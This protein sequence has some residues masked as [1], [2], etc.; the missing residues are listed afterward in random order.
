MI[1]FAA[2]GAGGFDQLF[3]PEHLAS[4][5]DHHH[6]EQVGIGHQGSHHPP[7]ETVAMASVEAE[8]LHVLIGSGDPAGHV[9]GAFHGENHPH[10][11]ANPFLTV[12]TEPAF[13]YP[14]IGHGC[15]RFLKSVS[16]ALAILWRCTQS[17]GSIRTMAFPIS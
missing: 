9:F 14:P 5:T 1:G 4:E 16:R 7:D 13:G 17:P 11:V 6:S 12:G 3:T 15:T 10:V 8:Q 2:R